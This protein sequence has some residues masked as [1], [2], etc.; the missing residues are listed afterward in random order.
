MGNKTLTKHKKM[1]R[2]KIRM[3]LLDQSLMSR[4]QTENGPGSFLVL[5]LQC[6]QKWEQKELAGAPSSLSGK[7]TGRGRVDRKPILSHQ[8][9]YD[10]SVRFLS[11]KSRFSR[12]GG[13]CELG[14]AQYSLVNI[15]FLKT[16]WFR[17][18]FVFLS[19]SSSPPLLIQ[20]PLEQRLPGLVNKK[21]GCPVKVACQINNNWFFSIHLSQIVLL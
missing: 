1:S 20:E 8:A 5:W 19:P 14:K 21:T 15:L 17:I 7:L 3:V 13:W 10:L 16:R 2:R 18:I 4:I 12:E 6:N 9:T 11:E